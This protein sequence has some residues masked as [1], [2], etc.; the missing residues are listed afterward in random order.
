MTIEELVTRFMSNPHYNDRDHEIASEWMRATRSARYD[1]RVLIAPKGNLNQSDSNRREQIMKDTVTYI[2]NHFDDRPDVIRSIDSLFAEFG[3][4]SDSDLR[5]DIIS[6]NKLYRH[7][8]VMVLL[9][10]H[11]QPTPNRGR[12]TQEDIAEYFLTTDRTIRDYLGELRPST[13]DELCAR[14]LGQIVRMDTKRGTNVPE[15]TTHPLFLPLN[16]LELYTL[17]DLLIR[18][19]NN[20]VEGRIICSILKCVLDQTTEYAKERLARIEGYE[21]A[22]SISANLGEGGGLGEAVMFHEKEAISAEVFYEEGG[23]EKSYKGIIS[24]SYGSRKHVDI[25]GE[26]GTLRVRYRDITR[27]KSL[28]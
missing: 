1:V 5:H 2:K 24:R 3:L 12:Y 23:V 17:V 8:E 22:V 14:V 28:R 4:D 16:M 19:V 11:L 13:D 6:F 10:K 21:E 7:D 9:L 18:H 25:T 27:L 15:S 26:E 20:E